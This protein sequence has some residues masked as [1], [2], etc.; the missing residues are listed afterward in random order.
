MTKFLKKLNFIPGILLIIIFIVPARIAENITRALFGLINNIFIYFD[1][2]GV[3]GGYI[4]M[5][6][7]KLVVEGIGAATYCGGMLLFPIFLNK[8]FFKKFQ[9]NWLPGIIL[10]FVIFSSFALF[11]LYSFI[12]KGLGK[13]DWID[14]ISLL[15]MFIGYSAGYLSI[16]YSSLKYSETKNKYIK[17]LL[18][19]F[20]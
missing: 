13:L 8:R 2:L 6:Y 16:I 11:Y 3:S 14:S 15:V 12:F 7:E 20:E 4:G 9:I 5:F 18:D 19:R 1:W 10:V 17:I